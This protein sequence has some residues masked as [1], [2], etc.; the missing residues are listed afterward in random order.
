MVKW[1]RRSAIV[2]YFAAKAVRLHL[3]ALAYNLGNFVFVAQLATLEPIK[4]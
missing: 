1:T 4:D 3:H 2:P